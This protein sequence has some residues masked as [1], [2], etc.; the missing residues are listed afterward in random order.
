MNKIKKPLSAHQYYMKAWKNLTEEEKRPFI[1]QSKKDK[2]R[3]VAEKK[4]LE[5]VE[6]EKMEELAKKENI[7]ISRSYDRVP[8]VGIDNGIESYEVIGPAEG[9]IVYTEKEKEELLKY[10]INEKYIPKYKTIIISEIDY[11]FDKISAKKYYFTAYSG[12]GSR[13][14]ITE[15]KEQEHY[16]ITTVGIS[17]HW[18]DEKPQS[19]YA[20][21]N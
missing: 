15:R 19:W 11:T 3:Y 5:D 10:G 4:A 2:E 14:S 18:R 1:E 6:K 16:T 13:W 7:F 9:F 17:G 8:R 12:V 21:K 20:V